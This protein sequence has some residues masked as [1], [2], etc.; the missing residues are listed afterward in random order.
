MPK[1]PPHHASSKPR[2]PKV[3]PD[4]SG[5]PILVYQVSNRRA[6][7]P[8]FTKRTQ[9]HKANSQKPTAKSCFYE[10]NPISSRPTAK[11][12]QPTAI[13][14]KRTQSEP[15]NPPNYTKRTQYQPQRTCGRPKNTKR[16]QFPATNIHSTIYNIQS[17]GPIS[18]RRHP[19]ASNYAKRTQFHKANSHL[20]TA[21]SCFYETN[22]IFTTTDLWRTKNAK[23]TQFSY[24]K[25]PTT[26]QICE[27][28]PIPPISSLPRWPQ[29]SPDAHRGTQF[30]KANCQQPKAAFTKRTQF[31]PANSRHNHK[32]LYSRELHRKRGRRDAWRLAQQ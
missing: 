32:S 19:A 26:P 2:W 25:C 22:P 4:L 10:T 5:N 9:F 1:Q 30:H 20:P 14:T 12:Q 13:F 15:G 18:A 11:T 8:Y 28:N 23:R 3:S 24:T 31:S 17:N 29:P 27:T 16:T 6:H 21:K 7:T